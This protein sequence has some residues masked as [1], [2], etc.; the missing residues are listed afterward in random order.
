MERHYIRGKKLQNLLA[1]NKITQMEMSD[2]RKY[3]MSSLSRAIHGKCPM[4]DDKIEAI[5]ELLNVKK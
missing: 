3:D 2:I 5:S 1:A 4:P